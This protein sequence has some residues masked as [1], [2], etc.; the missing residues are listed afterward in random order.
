M[1]TGEVFEKA[2]S[3]PQESV[4]GIGLSLGAPLEPWRG[5]GCTID[6]PDLPIGMV[7]STFVCSITSMPAR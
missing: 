4:Y 6:G 5:V 7:P 2:I 1:K 3:A